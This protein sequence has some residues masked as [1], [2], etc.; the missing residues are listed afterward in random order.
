MAPDRFG[1]LWPR[2]SP[3]P[4]PDIFCKQSA[5]EIYRQEQ[6]RREPTSLRFQESGLFAWAWQSCNYMPSALGE[7]KAC[8]V[9]ANLASKRGYLEEPRHEQEQCVT[10]NARPSYAH[11][12]AQTEQGREN[13]YSIKTHGPRRRPN[14]ISPIPRSVSSILSPNVS[15]SELYTMSNLGIRTE[16][17]LS[18]RCCFGDGTLP[19]A[20]DNERGL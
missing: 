12:H 1:G 7:A 16:L 14:G 3:T 8:G 9:T 20:A 15:Y 6:S 17:P 18:A 10:D 19:G 4:R 11:N 2:Q 13:R 5:R